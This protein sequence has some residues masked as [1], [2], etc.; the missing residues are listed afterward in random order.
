[1]RGKKQ[2]E[3]IFY[4]CFVFTF[5]GLATTMKK[6]QDGTEW[7]WQPQFPSCQSLKYTEILQYCINICRRK[8]SNFPLEVYEDYDEKV[9]EADAGVMKQFYDK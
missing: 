8:E 5:R 4:F 7:V 6:G 3:Y 1:M 2:R 9:I